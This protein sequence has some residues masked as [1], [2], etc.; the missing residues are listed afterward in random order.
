MGPREKNGHNGHPPLWTSFV[1]F[2]HVKVKSN[3]SVLSLT[4]CK[5][6][7]IRANELYNKGLLW[8]SVKTLRARQEKQTKEIDGTHIDC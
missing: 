8:D 3:A 2:S 6:T 7:L 1:Q 5:L 4:L